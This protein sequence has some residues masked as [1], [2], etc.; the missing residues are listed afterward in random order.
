MKADSNTG[1]DLK[2]W[3]LLQKAQMRADGGAERTFACT[4]EDGWVK[5]S[6]KVENEELFGST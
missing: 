3:L 6:T 5:R 1:V 4:E 2:L